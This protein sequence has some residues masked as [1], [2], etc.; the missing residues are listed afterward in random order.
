MVVGGLEGGD[1]G[2]LLFPGGFLG[3]E[4]SLAIDGEAAFGVDGG[5]VE[6]VEGAW[7]VGFAVDAGGDEFDEPFIAQELELLTD[8]CF[9]VVIVGVSGFQM[10]YKGVH[11]F[12]CE[13]CAEFLGALENIEQPAAAFDA[14]CLQ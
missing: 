14:L 1:E 7:L 4:G 12:Q 10:R 3:W 9:D 13:G 2:G 8:F 11:L 6:D 5:V